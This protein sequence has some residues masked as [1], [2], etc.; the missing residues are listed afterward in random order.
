VANGNAVSDA[1]QAELDQGQTETDTKAAEAD[2]VADEAKPKQ[3]KTFTEKEFEA[4][5][6]KIQKAAFKEAAAAKRDAD[7]AIARAAELEQSQSQLRQQLQVMEADRE[8]EYEEILKGTPEGD[9][10]I[11][12]YRHLKAREQAVVERELNAD[13]KYNTGEIGII[14]THAMRLAKE[15]GLDDHEVL[16]KAKSEPEMKVLAA[17]L[18]AQKLEQQIE[19]LRAGKKPPKPE[20]ELDDNPEHIDSGSKSVPVR[21]LSDDEF[22]TQYL[23]GK[24]TGPKNDKRAKEIVDKTLK[25]G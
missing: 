25:G 24:L 2:K 21:K 13:K 7:A 23:A 1:E 15:Y 8:R 19:D 9:K 4:Q 17:E 5:K 10:I 6:A 20:D 16:L 18:K 14:Y 11:A 22:T 3:E 12:L